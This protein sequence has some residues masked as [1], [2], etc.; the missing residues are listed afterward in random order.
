MTGTLIL[1]RHGESE[2]NLKNLF[3]G[4]KNPDLTE[5]GIAE[6]VR[7]GSCRGRGALD[8]DRFGA[9][10]QVQRACRVGGEVARVAGG[11]RAVVP[12][13]TVQPHSPPRHD[14]RR[15]VGPD[16]SQPVVQRCDQ[17]RFDVGPG[18]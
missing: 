2:W 11:G 14:M 18:E 4:W 8:D 15:A 3:T 16:S 5:K 1:V 7:V 9:V 17:P 12:E 13:P 10:L 6:A